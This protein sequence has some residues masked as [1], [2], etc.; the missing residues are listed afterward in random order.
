MIKF[1]RWLLVP[2]FPIAGLILGIW[3]MPE[4]KP[5]WE[6]NFQ[7][8]VAVK[9]LG[10]VDEGKTLLLIETK[11]ELPK[12]LISNNAFGLIGLNVTNGEQLFRTPLPDELLKGEGVF[13]QNASLTADGQGILFDHRVQ[14]DPPQDTYDEIVVYRWKAQEIIKR[15]RSAYGNGAIN[16]PMLR[17]STMAAEGSA[18]EN[19]NLLLWIGEEGK[20]AVLPMTKPIFDFGISDDG[21]MIYVCAAYASPFQ[22]ILVDAKKQKV[23]QT[24]EGHFREVRW[25]GD[26]QSF[27]AIEYDPMQKVHFARRYQLVD[28]EYVADPQSKIVI[29]NSGNIS[30]GKSH[31]TMTTSIQ[32]DPWRTRVTSWLGDKLKFIVDQLWPEGIALQLHDDYTGQLVH[33]LVFPKKER[34]VPYVHTDGQSV[35]MCDS[36]TVSFWDFHTASQWYPIYGLVIGLLFAILLAWRLLRQQLRITN[37][38]SFK[39]AQ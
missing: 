21:A 6:V 4:R 29:A 26:N 22:L 2:L 17:G 1:L 13:Y 8:T 36:R 11:V 32:F 20:P 30:R 5:R 34:G 31:L 23:M 27:L 24:I 12:H 7:D 16:W 14:I 9:G 3:L 19:H 25:A 39:G 15:Y 33:R 18:H 28:K 35:A 10:F 38:A 37:P